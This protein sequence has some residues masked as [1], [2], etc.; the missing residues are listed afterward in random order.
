MNGRGEAPLFFHM[1]FAFMGKLSA[2]LPL[3]AAFMVLGQLGEYST[4]QVLPVWL[5]CL[6]MDYISYKLY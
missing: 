2:S 1:V 3:Q 6:I 5:N 4:I